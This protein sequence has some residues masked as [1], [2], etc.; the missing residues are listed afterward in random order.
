MEITLTKSANRQGYLWNTLPNRLAYM[1][2]RWMTGCITARVHQT[3]TWR[4]W[5]VC[6]LRTVR[7]SS[8][9]S[10]GQ[11]LQAL[12]W[13]SDVASLLAEHIGA[14]AVSEGVQRLFQYTEAIHGLVEERFP[15]VERG[16]S[17]RRAGGFGVRG[18]SCGNRCGLPS[19]LPG[20][21]GFAMLCRPTSPSIWLKRMT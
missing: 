16:G 14:E 1:T 19:R 11:E 20:M 2:I 13:V 17:S 5:P 9:T 12:Y 6:C 3:T 10:I 8:A 15:E 21:T 18:P 4:S 7:V